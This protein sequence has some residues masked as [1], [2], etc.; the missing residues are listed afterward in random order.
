MTSTLMAWIA[1]ASA[2][3][4]SAALAEPPSAAR[5]LVD[6]Q[7]RSRAV[8]VRGFDAGAVRFTDARG[9]SRT[10]PLTDLVAI[11]PGT[12]ARQAR[13][14]T[15][16]SA[17]EAEESLV[18]PGQALRVDL[19]DGQRLVG[20]LSPAAGQDALRVID[21]SV[22]EIE[23]PLERVRAIR[24][25]GGPIAPGSAESA[26]L[27]ILA[28][29]DR[30]RGFAERV[31]TDIT[32]APQGEPA[33]DIPL[34]RA[35][36]L[37]LANPPAAPTGTMVALAGGTVIRVAGVLSDPLGQV[38]L[39]I[40][41]AGSRRATVRLGEIEAIA[42]DAARLRPLASL[43][44]AEVI[45]AP[46]RAFMPAPVVRGVD[47][48]LGLSDLELAGPGSVSW[49][50]EP[51]TG[52]VA[53]T[54]EL[55]RDQWVWGRANITLLAGERSLWTGEVSG[56]RPEAEFRAEVPAG[57]DRLTLRIQTAEAGPVG[58]KII[59]KRGMLLH[60]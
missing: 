30:L 9:S 1:G 19:I 53:G 7:L 13:G 36:E 10:E 14:R 60:N 16:A 20:R 29:G 50:L 39:S 51:R 11:L 4:G 2:L 32:F 46:G 47:A 6:K 31:G 21:E 8:M 55:P 59:I 26:D 54:I 24:F 44:V 28:N 56:D 17:D 25:D 5:V 49:T 3:L 35:A 37:R 40:E 41:S 34:A 52:R 43:P 18:A 12:S 38:E 23:T 48:V 15:H 27:L 45:P 22:G 33:R 57:A 58:G 42:L